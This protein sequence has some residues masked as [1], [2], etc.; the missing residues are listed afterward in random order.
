M[1][2]RNGY[3]HYQSYLA[4]HAT[5]RKYV[6]PDGQRFN[7]YAKAQAQWRSER[8]AAGPHLK[9]RKRGRPPKQAAAKEDPDHEEGVAP[10]TLQQLIEWQ[11][12]IA[13]T[14]GDTNLHQRFYRAVGRAQ[15]SIL[16]VRS[17]R[18]R[19]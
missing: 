2:I 19:V 3:I 12:S 9:K 11:R 18:A 5:D 14:L 16:Q 15:R 4:P 13:A 6:A 1:Q 8:S 7:T 10:Q 17:A